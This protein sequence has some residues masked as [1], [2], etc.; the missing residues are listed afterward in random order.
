MSN[1]KNVSGTHK[2]VISVKPEQSGTVKSSV[3]G[4]RSMRPST[5]TPP[6]KDNDKS[7]K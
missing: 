6:Q 2:L 3:E 7:N 4:I 1:K 5:P